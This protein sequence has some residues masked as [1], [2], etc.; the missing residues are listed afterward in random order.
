MIERAQRL[1]RGDN[2]HWWALSTVALGTFMS[3]LDSSIV[4]VSL[5]V[6]LQYFRTDLATI[7]WVVLAYLLTITALLLTFGRLA[8][9]WGRKRVYTIGFGVF[10]LGSLCC[11]LSGSPGQLIAA[12]V[13]Q[14][15]GGAMIQANGLAITSAVFPEEQ[16]G[17]ALGI[18]GTVV[19]TGTT[20]G[21][22]FGGLLTGTFGWQANFLVNL[23]VGIFGI[24]LA[25]LV[26]EERRISTRRPGAGKF[27][28]LGA[29]LAAVTLVTL[30]LALNRGGRAGWDSPA[31]LALLAV[32]AVSLVAFLVVES[33]VAAPLISLALFRIRSFATGSSAAFLSFLAIAAHFFLM[34]FFLQL[35]LGFPP[36]QAGLL[37]TPTSL[38]LAVVAPL[39]GYLSERLG[40]R[41]LSSIGLS[42]SCLA[43]FLLS[44]LTTDVHYLDVL[45]RLILLGVGMGLFNSPNS[46]AVFAS[47]PRAQYGVVGG[48]ISMVR[49]SGQAV[50]Q[51][52]AGAV[53]VSAIAPVVGSGGLDALRAGVGSGTDTAPLLRAFL[54]GLQHAYLLAAAFAACGALISVLRGSAPA[55]TPATGQQPAPADAPT[56]AGGAAQNAD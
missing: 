45:G 39:S 30:I 40:A 4:N 9:I 44:R 41:L 29:L 8:D 51:A 42:I 10:T 54:T 26:L 12:R 5:P 37:L 53:V 16:R 7:Q 32:A 31:I 1:V 3:T 21:P 14:A 28:P 17:R 55:T 50:G 49:N 18:Q 19:A 33:R 27:D 24:G 43:L 46:S 11:A 22:S 35:A 25:L 6:I 20:L 13:L 23:P 34:P 48:F 36:G 15:V 38:T 2:H 52:V 56:S 47:V